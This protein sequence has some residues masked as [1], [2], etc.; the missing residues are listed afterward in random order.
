M[1][2]PLI[3]CVIARPDIAELSEQIRT[4]FS[5][6]LLGGGPVLPLS[7]EDILSFVMAGSVSLM[8]GF[9]HQSLREFDPATACCDNLVRYAARRGLNMMS[10]TRAKGYVALTGDPEARIPNNLR[11]VSAAAYEYKLDPSIAWQ[12][13]QLDHAG[14]A[15]LRIVSLFGSGNYNMRPGE[16]L[17]LS[18]TV[19]GID[20]T[21][22]VVGSGL[23]GGTTEESCENLRRRVIDAEAHDVVS[24]NEAWYIRE[25]MRYPGVT[26]ACTEAC[27]G[28][29]DPFNI[30]IYPFMEGVYGDVTEPPYGVPPCEVLEEM[31]DWMWGPEPGRGKG[32]AP[33]GVVGHYEA[34]LPTVMNVYAKCFAGCA[35]GAEER[36]RAALWTYIRATFCIGSAVCKDQLRTVIYNALGPTP[37]MSNVRF[38]FPDD[39]IRYEDDNNFYL[40][41]AHFLVVGEIFLQGPNDPDPVMGGQVE[42]VH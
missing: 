28:C 17:V 5:K 11:F 20:H 35:I 19:P 42:F 29:C 12:P 6:R 30:A 40:D 32:Y 26:R 15:V 34:G 10:A 36:I 9:V 2:D 4:E 1:A 25:T 37:C 33:V 14:G 31:N 38:V 7:S 27:Q 18:T 21:A 24:T 16:T 13:T 23:T 39:N 22:T 41:C 3:S 8:Y